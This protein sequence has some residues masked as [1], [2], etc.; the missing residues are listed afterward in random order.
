MGI[1]VGTDI[2]K[3]DRIRSSYEKFGVK[4]LEK[5]FTKSEQVYCEKKFDKFASYAARFAAKEAFAKACGF[6]IGEEF[7]WLDISVENNLQ[8]S[9]SLILSNSAH[10]I[11]KDLNFT[12]AKVSMSHTDDIANAVVILT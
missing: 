6:G 4:F 12:E 1:A 11:L 3:I 10:N 7:S 9:P 8:G 5:I 2:I